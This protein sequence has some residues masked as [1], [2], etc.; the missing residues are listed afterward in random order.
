[1]QQEV[2]I[3]VDKP[4]LQTPKNSLA[5][6]ISKDSVTPAVC[7]ASVTTVSAVEIKRKNW[8]EKVSHENHG[9]PPYCP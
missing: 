5:T 3:H 2:H 4:T 7:E 6:N 1:M 9:F 8:V